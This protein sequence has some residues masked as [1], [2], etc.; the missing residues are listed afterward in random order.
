MP[1]ENPGPYPHTL[2]INPADYANRPN[3]VYH[4]FYQVVTPFDR[5]KHLLAAREEAITEAQKNVLRNL[6]NSGT[7]PANLVRNKISGYLGLGGSKG[8]K[9]RSVKRHG[10]LGRTH[11]R[12]TYKS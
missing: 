5:R 8:R 3:H 2:G 6:G 12:R 4:R 10:R 9:R 7:L 11:K 1:V